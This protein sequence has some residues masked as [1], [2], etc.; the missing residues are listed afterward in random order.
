MDA[1]LSFPTRDY[2]LEAR[3]FID[4][5]PVWWALIRSTALEF[6]RE[7]R[8]FGMKQLVE[9]SRFEVSRRAIAKAGVVFRI[10]NNWT[11]TFARLL[12]AELPEVAP[13]I[14]T[15]RAMHAPE[16]VRA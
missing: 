7:G 13:Y 2:A 10:N 16:G 4:D 11:S 15:R 3:A 12:I 6:A 1:Q 14:E 9:W 5:N 8:R